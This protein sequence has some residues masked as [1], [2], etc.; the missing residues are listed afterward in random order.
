MLLVFQDSTHP[1]T[2][3]C[4][5]P[6]TYRV[7]LINFL[8][9]SHKVLLSF[10]VLFAILS[11]SHPATCY[12]QNFLMSHPVDF[13]LLFS[14]HDVMPGPSQRAAHLLAALRNF[15]MNFQS[16]ERYC[17]TDGNKIIILERIYAGFTNIFLNIKHLSKCL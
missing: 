14:W 9:T 5:T 8:L 11:V 7:W 12:I 1:E 17:R 10:M 13:D 3:Q 16:L 6:G 4:S 15:N 2:P